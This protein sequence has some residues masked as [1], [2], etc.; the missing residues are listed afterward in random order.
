MY[1]RALRDLSKEPS[2]K[3]KCNESDVDRLW[4]KIRKNFKNFITIFISPFFPFV[5]LCSLSHF[6]IAAATL[7]HCQAQN[8]VVSLPAERKNG[9]RVVI[10]KKCTALGFLKPI[11]V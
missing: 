11:N 4:Q 1:C 8:M 10:T 2:Y 5:N 3:K 6:M 7:L 9:E